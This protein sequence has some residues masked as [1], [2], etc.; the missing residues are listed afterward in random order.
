MCIR[1]RLTGSL[2]AAVVYLSNA[3]GAGAKLDALAIQGI[4]CS[5]ATQPWAVAQES[6]FPQLASR[7]FQSI[8]SEESQEVFAAEGF[9]WQLGLPNQSP[10]G[11]Q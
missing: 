9:R 5:T 2:D 7:L 1:D 3:A 11:K 4:E 10:S 8:C 6:A